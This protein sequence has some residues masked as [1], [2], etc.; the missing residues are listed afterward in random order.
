[1][2]IGRSQIGREISRGGKAPKLSV[3]IVIK[4]PK[5]KKG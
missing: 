4:R 5:P 1:M 2:A 3:K